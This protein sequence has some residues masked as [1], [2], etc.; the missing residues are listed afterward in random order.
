[1][2]IVP[3][4]V[5]DVLLVQDMLLLS[6]HI[7]YSELI[8]SVVYMFSLI[9]KLYRKSVSETMGLKRE[10]GAEMRQTY[11]HSRPAR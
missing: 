1:M 8:Y 9:Y 7:H 11:S 3:D 5:T 6:R 4:Y 10:H 2:N